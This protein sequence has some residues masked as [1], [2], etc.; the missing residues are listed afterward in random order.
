MHRD[1]KI[2]ELMKKENKLR[3]LLDKDNGKINGTA[4]VHEATNCI[5]TLNG[6]QGANIVMRNI[7]VLKDN[8]MSVSKSVNEGLKLDQQLEPLIYSVV[9]A[10]T[11]LNLNAIKE[12]SDLIEKYLNPNIYNIVENSPLVD[13]DVTL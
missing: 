9:W 2:N 10:T 3:E 13:L 8:S 6:V 12:F 1:R 11:R 4:V 7:N 5:T